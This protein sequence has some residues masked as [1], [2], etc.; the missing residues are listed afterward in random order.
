MVDYRGYNGGMDIGD[1]ITLAAV[2]V[3]LGIGVA[4]ILQT[5]IMQRRDRKERLLN[6]IIEWAIDILNCGREEPFDWHKILATPDIIS[7]KIIA[8]N[9]NMAYAKIRACGTPI[10]DFANECDTN[11]GKLVNEVH[12]DL[13]TIITT[14]EKETREE[15]TKEE[16]GEIRK[17][18][19]KKATELI[20]QAARLLF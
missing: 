3:A 13:S 9:L 1:W 10:I 7:L 6:E 11:L 5:Q 18:L 4:S 14:T 8:A 15:A 2:I 19:E 16:V 20:K 17:E 12:A